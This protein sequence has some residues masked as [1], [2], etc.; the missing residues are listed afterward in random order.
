MDHEIAD[1]EE[2][3]KQL[4]QRH[5]SIWGAFKRHLFKA[6]TPRMKIDTTLSVSGVAP[7]SLSFFSDRFLTIDELDFVGQF[8][9]SPNERYLVGWSDRSPDGKTGGHRYE[10]MG[11]WILI[12]DNYLIAEGRLQRP[13]DGKVADNGTVL[14]S[15][16]LFG[17]NLSGVLAAFSKDGEQ[18]LAKKF[19]A[20]LAD[21]ALSSDGAYAICRTLNSPGSPDSCQIALFDILSG[22]E[23]CRWTPEPA[24]ISGFEF[25]VVAEQ[26]HVLAEDG[27][28][29]SY[30]FNG[31]ML[32]AE[33]WRSARLGRGDLNAI[34]AFIDSDGDDLL[35]DTVDEILKAIDT[36][37]KGDNDWVVA[38]AL[39]AKGE[40]LE[41]LN[42]PAEALE[43]YDGA[44]V[45]DPK[46]GVSRRAE[47]LRRAAGS[48]AKP[49]MPRKGRLEKQAERLGIQHETIKLE[50]GDEKSWRSAPHRDWTSIENAALDYYLDEGWSG[51]SAEGGL[52]LTL[53]K[54]ASF[55]RLQERH[56]NTFIEALYG[57][58]VAF[59]EDRFA[60]GDLLASIKRA[61][62]R[63]LQ[64]NWS[65]I[66]KRAG[67]TPAFYPNVFWD[68]VA[69]LYAALGNE[70]LA[71]IAERFASAPY[72]LRAGWPDLTLWSSDEVRFVEV[73]SQSDSLHASQSRLI[74]EVLGPLNYR[75]TL[76]EVR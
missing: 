62:L 75:V 50:K 59:D 35:P 36:A 10:G 6:D 33:E 67:H 27:D 2:W 12:R 60:V 21:H 11:R 34:K 18:L 31:T 37:S 30:D 25:D 8:S 55:P 51:A 56:A 19:S 44:L 5:M 57:Q 38:R 73:K 47:K 74:R 68:S 41:K 58:N 29:A 54:A 15:D 40:F 52:I 64:E 63:Q 42:R 1:N 43:A 70:R 46:V 69:G 9:K 24:P 16:W 61:N 76:A 32:N 14:L 65:L 48:Q 53:I 26:V 3:V 49:K 39:R 17:D 20:K 72:D 13:Q 28:R 7:L 23:L 22:D 45:R 4:G 71:A 66:S